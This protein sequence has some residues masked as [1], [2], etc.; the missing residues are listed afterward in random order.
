LIG[1]VIGWTVVAV[2][3]SV[4]WFCAFG[5][6]VVVMPALAR[7]FRKQAEMIALAEARTQC[8][9]DDVP[10]ELRMID[11]SANDCAD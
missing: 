3:L 5:W 4:V 8:M 9:G 6:R 7:I 1:T 10:D 11:T 2:W